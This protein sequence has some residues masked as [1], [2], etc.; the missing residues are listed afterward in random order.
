MLKAIGMTFLG[1][2]LTGGGFFLLFFYLIGSSTGRTPL[3]L[4][5]ST[6]CIAGGVFLLLR[7]GKSNVT[8]FALAEEGKASI[9]IKKSTDGKNL[10]EKSNEYTAEWKKTN[11]TKDRL[12]MLQIS[13]NAEDAK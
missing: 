13:A 3:L 2:G 12:K 7:A 8:T 4:I 6:I 9:A 1:L 11:D 5:P 10:L